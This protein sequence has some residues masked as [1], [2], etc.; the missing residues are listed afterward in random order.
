MSKAIPLASLVL[1]L[2]LGWFAHGLWP[3][4]EA[5]PEP[6]G[7]LAR[8][9]DDYVSEAEFIDEMRRRGG[10]RPGQYQ[11]LEQRRA[12]LDDL[13]FRRALVRAARA[14]GI[15]ARP[16]VRRSLDQL[17]ANQ[18]L[19]ETLRQQQASIRVTEQDVLRHYQ[20]QAD[21]YT[22]PGRRR[23]AMVRIEVPAASDEAVWSNAMARAAEALAKAR[24]QNG[25]VPH[26]GVVAQ[27]Y[28]QDQA[29][30]YRGGVIG[31]IAEGQDG[32]Y[33]FDP[34][35]L[36]AA[37]RLSEGEY[38]GPLRGSDAVYLVRVVEVQEARPRSLE[39]L[40]AGIHQ[41][42]LRE[43]MEASEAEFR[44]QLL[45]RSRIEVREA[46]L[47]RIDPLSPP[48][49]TEPPRPPALPAD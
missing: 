5:A 27:E 46:R 34:V 24:E 13:V 35:V 10:D 8:V 19:Q 7:W 14:E 29:S 48:A 3:R 26:F 6:D 18:Y 31:W 28:S 21:D 39:E 1:G 38:S 12:L 45:A 32:R 22:V 15:D 49:S 36:E 30:R 4:G 42:L 9:A 25:R 44:Q 17:L 33:A 23:V 40:S 11:T 37:R 43:R 47:A 41:R 16:E 2:A 20:A